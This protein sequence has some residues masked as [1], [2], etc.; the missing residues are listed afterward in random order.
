M[1]IKTFITSHQIKAIAKLHQ[2]SSLKAKVKS[3]EIVVKVVKNIAGN[4][5]FIVSDKSFFKSIFSFF[6]NKSVNKIALF[7][8]TQI[9]QNIQNSQVLRQIF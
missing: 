9:T 5:S 4:L 7:I 3:Q 6:V 2:S 1:I 8:P